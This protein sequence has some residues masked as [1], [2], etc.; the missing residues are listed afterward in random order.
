MKILLNLLQITSVPNKEKIEKLNELKD[1]SIEL[2]V[3]IGVT[4]LISV[5]AIALVKF[6]KRRYV[7]IK[8]DDI[9]GNVHLP[10][11]KDKDGYRDW[12][13]D[14]DGVPDSKDEDFKE[15]YEKK[16]TNK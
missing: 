15:F 10:E 14:K 3:A 16:E 1:T 2:Y 5:I 8:M 9:G 11:D 4:I 6:F 7:R 12:D 13:L